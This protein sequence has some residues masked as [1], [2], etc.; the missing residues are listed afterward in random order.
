M[1]S[2]LG[3]T[4]SHK[5]LYF[6][7]P[8]RELLPLFTGMRERSFINH[9]LPSELSIDNLL[10]WMGTLPDWRSLQL[11]NGVQLNLHVQPPQVSN[12]LS[13]VTA[14]PKHQNFPSQSLT[15]ETSSKWPTPISDRDHFLGLKLEW[16]S[17]VL[18]S[19]KRSLDAFSDLYI[20]LLCAL[21]YLGCVRLGNPDLES[22]NKY[23]SV[24]IRFRISRLIA[25]P[26]SG[27]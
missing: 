7:T 26:K 22:K 25:N 16:F 9:Y 21:C 18:T 11:L 6:V 23:F 27:F 15:V 1:R 13:S 3:W 19:C 17:I 2:R 10:H 24:E 5:S 8:Y 4:V 20:C 12:H 14:N